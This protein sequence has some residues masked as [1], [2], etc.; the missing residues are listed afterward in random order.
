M[1]FYEFVSFGGKNWVV[2]SLSPQHL[3]PL[4][5]YCP[6]L[7][8]FLYFFW[9]RKEASASIHQKVFMAWRRLLSQV[10]AVVVP[11]PTCLSLCF[12]FFIFWWSRWSAGFCADL[13]TWAALFFWGNFVALSD[14]QWVLAVKIV[15]LTDLWLVMELVSLYVSFGWCRLCLCSYLMCFLGDKNSSP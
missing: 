15:S 3:P 11:L 1:F 13:N 10:A 4:L 9:R 14:G 12:F 5:L 7:P 2:S 8:Y 6:I